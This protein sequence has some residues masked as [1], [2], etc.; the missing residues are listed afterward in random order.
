[1]PERLSPSLQQAYE[2]TR[3]R[4]LKEAAGIARNFCRPG[5]SLTAREPPAIIAEIRRA[6]RLALRDWAV[7]IG[8]LADD[9]VFTA[10][11]E[12]Q[13]RISG[14][15]NDV[16]LDVGRVRKRNNLTF[17]LTYVDFFDRLALQNLFFPAAAV[18]FEGFTDSSALYLVFSQPFILAARGARRDEVER[19]MDRS[20]YTRIRGDDYN[21]REGI[22]IEDV[23]D[24]NA[25][26]DEA[27][28]L[29]VVDP[30]IYLA[31]HRPVSKTGSPTSRHPSRK[32]LKP[33]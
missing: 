20:G 25:F 23:H 32:S 15:E 14:Q 4:A 19:F 1:M 3:D 9:A 5:R 6:E 8:L 22:L 18:S 27:G 21:N 2:A 10:K 17:H 13:G 29:I 12:A 11:W 24:E 33:R 16:F 7:R 26:I 28:D 31:D 30:V